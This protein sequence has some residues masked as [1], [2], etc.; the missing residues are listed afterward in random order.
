MRSDWHTYYIAIQIPH[1]S[2]HPLTV[3]GA[4]LL[5]CFFYSVQPEL[6]VHQSGQ[7]GRQGLPKVDGER[8]RR[9]RRSRR[10]RR[11]R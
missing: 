7:V 3:V 2:I 6:L 9:P 11:P 4:H 10:G 1:P 5:G 8:G